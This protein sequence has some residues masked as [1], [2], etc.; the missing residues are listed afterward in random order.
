MEQSLL[1][2]S[3]RNDFFT[4]DGKSITVDNRDSANI[5]EINELSESYLL[6][7]YLNHL[8]ALKLFLTVNTWMRSKYHTQ[9]RGNDMKR[10]LNLG[11]QR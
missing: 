3:L 4:E 9:V 8:S 11:L 2:G 5:D 6:G 10:V 7:E 1:R